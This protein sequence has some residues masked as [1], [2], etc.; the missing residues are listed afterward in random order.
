MVGS[1]GGAIAGLTL[2]ACIQAIHHCR[3]WAHRG[4]WCQRVYADGRQETL[5]GAE[6]CELDRPTPTPSI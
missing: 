5:Y 1:I 3:I 4:I 6:A 2:I